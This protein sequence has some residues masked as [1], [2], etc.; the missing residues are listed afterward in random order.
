MRAL[1]VSASVMFLG[2]LVFVYARREGTKEIP[3]EYSN[4]W[5]MANSNGSQV[6]AGTYDGFVCAVDLEK[7]LM[8]RTK[9]HIGGVISLDLST[10]RGKL[11]SGGRDGVINLWD[12]AKI[13]DSFH[14]HDGWVHFVRFSQEKVAEFYSGGSR[15][16]MRWSIDTKRAKTVKCPSM[17]MSFVEVPEVNRLF[18]G[19]ANGV[20]YS[21]DPNLERFEPLGDHGGAVSGLVVTDSGKLASCGANKKIKVWSLDPRRLETVLDLHESPIL[22]MATRKNVIATGDT[23]GVIVVFDVAANR[24]IARFQ[25]AMGAVSSILFLSDHIVVS[26][27]KERTMEC[28]DTRAEEAQ[29]RIAIR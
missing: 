19:G 28:W 10:D 1:I 4:I 18:I 29:K 3:I 11:V 27:S 25:S 5:S 17:P 15:F 8:W 12:G 24:K 22:C 26:G 16:L 6:L 13:M 9:G 2:V 23:S 7:G 14:P 20:V 21:V